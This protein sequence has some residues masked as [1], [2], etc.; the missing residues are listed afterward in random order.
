MF[1][2]L[3]ITSLIT[4]AEQVA[5]DGLGGRG[6]WWLQHTWRFVLL[7]ML[8]SPHQTLHAFCCLSQSY[9]NTMA[10]LN[11]VHGGAGGDPPQSSLSLPGGRFRGDQAMLPTCQDWTKR[12]PLDAAAHR[13]RGTDMMQA[14]QDMNSLTG[15]V[16]QM[17][18]F[19]SA[20]RF[21]IPFYLII[22]VP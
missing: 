8:L 20:I 7:R 11:G 12:A 16:G 10:T 15:Q 22:R 13:W 14:Q 21:Y 5:A 4:T 2:W 1:K 17:E 3:K 18:E 9:R 6:G 19:C